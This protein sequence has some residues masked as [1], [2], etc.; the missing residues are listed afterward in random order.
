[1]VLL[2]RGKQAFSELRLFGNLYEKGAHGKQRFN[3]G[4][5]PKRCQPNWINQ[6]P[7]FN[8]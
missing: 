6:L 5:Y 1:M 3:L 4:T 7:G 8:K 2:K